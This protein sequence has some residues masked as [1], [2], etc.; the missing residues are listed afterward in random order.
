M[1]S[2]L[3]LL[4]TTLLR[5]RAC[6]RADTERMTMTVKA[7][8]EYTEELL[9]KFAR[10]SIMR[11][12]RQV[13]TYIVGELIMLAMAGFYAYL[14]WVVGG[15]SV[16]IAIIFLTTIPYIIPFILWRAPYKSV[17]MSKRVLGAAN[18]YEFSDDEII[19]ESTFPTAE[20][21]TKANYQ[22]FDRVYETKTMFCF[23]T[24]KVQA[25]IMNKSDIT[26][27][28]ITDL[29]E[30]L[31]KNLPPKKYIVRGKF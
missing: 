7:K 29:Q 30:L 15:G 19:I 31:R 27:G 14:T 5:V 16:V 23:F 11:T 28:T 10:F 3:S 1:R 26:E 12:P 2:H 9:L 4:P 18:Y 13:V 20:G 21:Q 6:G 24:S 8:T 25:C 22:F 17:K